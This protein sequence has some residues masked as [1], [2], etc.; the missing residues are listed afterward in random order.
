M[1]W[2]QSDL[3]YSQRANQGKSGTP[4]R[5]I[6]SMADDAQDEATTI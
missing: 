2:Q 1:C 6:P 3:K 4:R 5:Q